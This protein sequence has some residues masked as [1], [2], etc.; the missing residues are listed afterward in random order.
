MTIYF[1]NQWWPDSPRHICGTR[2]R[3]VNFTNTNRDLWLLTT[4]TNVLVVVIKYIN[5]GYEVVDLSLRGCI[6]IPV[7]GIK[8]YFIKIYFSIMEIPLL[9]KGMSMWDCVD[10]NCPKQ[11]AVILARLSPGMSC[12]WLVGWLI[13]KLKWIAGKEKKCSQGL[14]QYRDTYKDAIL[15]A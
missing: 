5:M 3:W 8:D 1:L 2:E 15:L 14:S 11:S 7:A 9:K 6:E 4:L 10:A 12:N 13:G